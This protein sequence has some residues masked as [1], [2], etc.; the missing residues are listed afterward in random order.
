M[1]ASGQRYRWLVRP[2]GE[3]LAPALPWLLEQLRP[4]PTATPASGGLA[5]LLSGS[6]DD[7]GKGNSWMTG[8]VGWFVRK[9][10]VGDDLAALAQAI[11]Q[12]LTHPLPEGDLT[13]MLEQAGGWSG[14]C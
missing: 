10:V 7:P 14:C 8:V 3:P 9:G 13:K 11:Q 12:G 6:P 5:A 1:H 4:A 2:N